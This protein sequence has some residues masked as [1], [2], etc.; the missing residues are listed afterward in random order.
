MRK[1]PVARHKDL[2]VEDLPD[3]VLIYDLNMD[4]AHC[5]NQTAALIWKNCDG[6]KSVGEIATSL[7]QE[8]EAP[9]SQQVVRLGLEELSVYSPL[10]EKTWKATTKTQL[11]RRE[12]VKKLGLMAAIALPVIISITAPTRAQAAT[13]DPCAVSSSKPIGCPC[14]SDNECASSNCNAGTCG[15]ELRPSK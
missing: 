1:F 12:L 3:E 8:L 9:V 13:V 5:L 11:S 7:E 15:P 6:Q 14:L 2:I 4:K 10:K